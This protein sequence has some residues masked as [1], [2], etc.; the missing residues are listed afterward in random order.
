MRFLEHSNG[1]NNG[2]NGKEPIYQMTILSVYPKIKTKKK[3]NTHKQ[4]QPIEV[5]EH[6]EISYAILYVA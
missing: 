2:S 5:K 1:T 4:K 3:K 6:P